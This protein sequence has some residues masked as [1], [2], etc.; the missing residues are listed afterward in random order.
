MHEGLR[1]LLALQMLLL[2]HGYRLLLL[3]DLYTEA[4]DVDPDHEVEGGYVSDRVIQAGVLAL[5]GAILVFP[6]FHRLFCGAFV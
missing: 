4:V 1:G 3:A 6:G 5:I 2:L